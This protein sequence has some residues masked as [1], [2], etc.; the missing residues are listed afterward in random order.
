MSFRHLKSP[1]IVFFYGSLVLIALASFSQFEFL[2]TNYWFLE[3]WISKGPIIWMV[4]MLVIHRDLSRSGFKKNTTNLDLIATI[5]F[6]PVFFLALFI[7]PILAPTLMVIFAWYLVSSKIDLT[8]MLI[9]W[10]FLVFS[11]PFYYFELNLIIRRPS[12]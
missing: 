5:F 10:L 1:Q 4:S 8:R 11:L 3:D 7:D 9:V 6:V 12:S 2:L